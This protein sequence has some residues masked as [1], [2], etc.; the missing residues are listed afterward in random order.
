MGNIIKDIVQYCNRD[1]VQYLKDKAEK[2]CTILQ[3]ENYAIRK[4]QISK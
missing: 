3:G 2:Y 4:I 1:I